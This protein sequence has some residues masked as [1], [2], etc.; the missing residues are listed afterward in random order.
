MLFHR[1]GQVEE[2]SLMACIAPGVGELGADYVNRTR[3]FGVEAQGPAT[4]PSPL[5]L[6][7]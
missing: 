3:L 5:N 7:R 4:R 6:S 1:P 2:A